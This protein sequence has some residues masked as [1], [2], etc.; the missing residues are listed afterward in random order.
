MGQNQKMSEQLARMAAQQEAI[1]RQMQQ[2]MD[3]LKKQKHYKKSF[4]LKSRFMEN[5]KILPMIS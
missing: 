1:R 3:E 2:Y 4:K 5:Y